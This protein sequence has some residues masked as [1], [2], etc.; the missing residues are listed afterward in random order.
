MAGGVPGNGLGFAAAAWTRLVVGVAFCAAAVAMVWLIERPRPLPAAAP[1]GGDGGA[2]TAPRSWPLTVESTYAVTT[3]AVV[4]GGG[5]QPAQH[6][7]AYT[8]S[9]RVSATPGDEILVSATPGPAD[10]APNHGLR[11]VLGEAQPRLVW[12][13]GEVT[14]TVTVPLAAGTTTGAAP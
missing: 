13:G 4:V 12:S 9:G 10:Q 6:S 11:I 3:W 8:W 5:A 14:A 1:A 2:T 7:D